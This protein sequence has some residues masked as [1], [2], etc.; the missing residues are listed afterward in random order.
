MQKPLSFT[1]IIRTA[2]RVGGAA[3]ALSV[4]AASNAAAQRIS[5]PPPPPKA[6]ATTP[7]KPAPAP[8]TASSWPAPPTTS[9]TA[10]RTPPAPVPA[11][12]AAPAPSSPSTSFDRRPAAS[13]IAANAVDYRLGAGDKLR[14]EVF[15][16]AQLSQSVQVRPDGK[17]TLP[18]IGDV[19]ASGRTPLELKDSLTTAWGEY[20]KNPEV[21]VMV[22]EAAAALAYVI[23]EVNN[24]GAVAVTNNLT[25]LQALAM[26]G[27]PTDWANRSKIVILR[28]GPGGTQAIPFNYKD[29]TNPKSPISPV[30]LQAG[31]TVVVP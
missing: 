17:I 8:T 9:T 25:V 27:G 1:Q 28:P 21:T 12:A 16:D 30:F 31:D 24:Q 2:A 23:G 20:L 14:I 10:P 19:I 29:A 15:K 7:A 5:T 4:A 3:L 18:L 26:A 6:P 22:T 13:S 11:S